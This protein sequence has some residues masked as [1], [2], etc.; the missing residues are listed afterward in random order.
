MSIKFILLGSGSSMG[1]PRIDGFFGK[2]DPKNIKNHRTRCSALIR[3]NNYNILIDTSPDLRFQLLKCK[4]KNIDKVLFTHQHADQTHG[5]NDL[6]TF[7]LKTGKKIPVYADNQTAKYLRANF[8]YCFNKKLDYPPILKLQRLKKNLKFDY[9]LNIK[10]IPI[11]HGRIQCMSYIINNKLA[12]ASDINEIY[13]KD[14]NHFKNLKY[15]VID[16]LRIKKHPSHFNLDDIL[17]LNYLIKPK[18]TILT[19]MHSDLDY[20]RL[21]KIL[22]K[23][24]KP[25]FDGLTLNI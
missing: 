12:Y 15:L 16:C 1:V 22:P 3:K 24:I 20:N 17:K 9:N 25:G 10:C 7:Y 19:N 6:R 8:S 23:N 5:I 21:L 18:K 4:I 14:L 2:C 11:R 13:Q